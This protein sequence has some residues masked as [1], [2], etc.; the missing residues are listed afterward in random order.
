MYNTAD[1][2]QHAIDLNVILTGEDAQ[3]MGCEKIVATVTQ[4]AAEEDEEKTPPSSLEGLASFYRIQPRAIKSMSLYH[5]YGSQ[6]GESDSRILHRSA[7]SFQTHDNAMDQAFRSR[8]RIPNDC[9]IGMTVFC[10]YKCSQGSSELAPVEDDLKH[11]VK[12]HDT[13]TQ[14]A[15]ARLFSSPSGALQSG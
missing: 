12:E 7:Q 13:E 15:A 8:W 4:S 5:I 6:D 10:Q 3:A 11:A 2:P 1:K 14:A 9:V